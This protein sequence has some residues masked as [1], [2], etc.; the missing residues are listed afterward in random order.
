M[1]KTMAAEKPKVATQI[2]D[3]VKTSKGFIGIVN[4]VREN[5]VIIDIIELPKNSDFEHERTV[6][7]HKNYKIIK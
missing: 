2:G 6:V 1:Y 5:S 7:N 4:V 3:K